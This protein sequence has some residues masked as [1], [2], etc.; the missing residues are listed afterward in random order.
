MTHAK[1]SLLKAKNTV[2]DAKKPVF[3]PIVWHVEAY[4]RQSCESSVSAQPSTAMSVRQISVVSRMN[5]P[6]LQTLG[7]RKSNERGENDGKFR[8]MVGRLG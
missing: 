7:S 3:K 8:Q 2:N 4:D 1:A 6:G 5:S